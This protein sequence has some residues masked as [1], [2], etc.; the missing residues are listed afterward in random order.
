MNDLINKL[1]SNDL[2]KK[3]DSIITVLDKHID[4]IYLITMGISLL[5]MLIS[6]TLITEDSVYSFAPKVYN[7]LKLIRYATY[8]ILCGIIFVYIWKDRV[9][10]IPVILIGVVGFLTLLGSKDFQMFSYVLFVLGGI[11]VAHKKTLK[12]YV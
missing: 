2:V 11:V 5:T 7:V 1:K 6:Q 8:L 12:T 3:L 4:K 10:R 9:K